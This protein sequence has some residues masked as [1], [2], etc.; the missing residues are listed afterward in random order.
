MTAWQAA[1]LDWY[2]QVRRPLPWRQTSDPYAI[3]LS[4]VLLQQTRVDQALPYYLR[5][6]ERFPTLVDLGQA[7]LEEVLLLWQG[8]GYYT[9]TRNLHR[10]AQQLGDQPLPTSYGQLLELP[11]LGPYTAAAVASIAFGQPVAAVDGNIRRVIARVTAQSQPSPSGLAQTAQDWLPP[12]EAGD[13]NQ[14]LM[15]LGATVC[16]PRQPRCPV[17]PLQ[18]ICKGQSSP[19]VYPAP[20]RRS[21][22][23]VELVALVLLGPQGVWLEQRQSRSLGGLWG[24]P[25]APE[26][27]TLLQQYGLTQAQPAGQVSHA[28]THRQLTI[29]VYWATWSGPGFH[30]NHKPLAQLDRKILAQALPLAGHQGV[31][32]PAQ[33]A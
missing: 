21:Q 12:Q 26:L 19:E 3:L 28:F 9:R 27:K 15:E 8:L 24:V 11:G 7:P 25:T 30:P 33:D 1:L 32:P 29:R 23:R 5:I 18:T 22:K 31:V 14:A 6:L 20:T 17:C 2:R 16:T 13:W 10:L 4:E